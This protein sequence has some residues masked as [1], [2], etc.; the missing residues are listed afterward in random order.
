MPKTNYWADNYV[1]KLASAEK[2]LQH[3]QPGQRVFIG[4]SCGEPQHLV[5]ELSKA[6]VRFTDLEIVR[7]LCIERGP[8]T[9]VANRAHSKQFNIR[10]F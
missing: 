5:K 6:S 7:L 1:E 4:S 8:L 10:S 3:I 2:A 9:L